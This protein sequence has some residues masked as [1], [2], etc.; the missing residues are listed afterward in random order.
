MSRSSAPL[1]PS[2][3]PS[4]EVQRAT[5]HFFGSFVVVRL[6]LPVAVRLRYFARR[7]RRGI[8]FHL[9]LASL[10]FG[11]VPQKVATM[12]PVK[13]FMAVKLGEG[14]KVQFPEAVLN[15][16][17]AGATIQFGTISEVMQFQQFLPENTVSAP[18]VKGA[19]KKPS[20]EE[21]APKRASVFTRLSITSAPAPT[22]QKEISDPKLKSAIVNSTG[23]NI[24]PEEVPRENNIEIPD[25]S[26]KLSRKARRK[27]NARLRANGWMPNTL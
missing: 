23:Q 26:P 7:R 19:A 5:P 9:L 4:Q 18:T 14:A 11:F 13:S 27:A 22:I 10:L 17:Y 21:K 25:A 12:T 8:A 15:T 3:T 2:D 6:R 16:G 1:L 20:A 24:T